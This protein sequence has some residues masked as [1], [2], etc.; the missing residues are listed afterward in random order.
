MDRVPNCWP[1]GEMISKPVFIKLED[2]TQLRGIL[3]NF[4]TVGNLVLANTELVTPGP[5]VPS[6]FKPRMLG[7]AVI[8]SP[9]IASINVE[10]PNEEE[11]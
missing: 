11:K 7:A 8:R 2:G 3:K 9:H 4:D 1:L 10:N 6:H 5:K